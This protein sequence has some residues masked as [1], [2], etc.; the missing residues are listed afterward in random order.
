[1]LL[2]SKGKVLSTRPPCLYRLVLKR[3]RR[4]TTQRKGLSRAK[5]LP[6]S[7]QGK[8]WGREETLREKVPVKLMLKLGP[9]LGVVS[10]G[11]GAPSHTGHLLGGGES[12]QINLESEIVFS[13][14]E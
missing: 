7:G 10:P 14:F 8:S 9:E 5:T 4:G 11:G 2:E 3:G 12:T 13:T 6:R 1:M